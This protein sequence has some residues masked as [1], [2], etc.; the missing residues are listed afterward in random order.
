MDPDLSIMPAFYS[1]SNRKYLSVSLCASSGCFAD[2]RQVFIFYT[3]ENRMKTT[4]ERRIETRGPGPHKLTALA[5]QKIQN[6]TF[7]IELWKSEF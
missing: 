4:G 6:N 7:R 2:T 1:H 3:E 5:S